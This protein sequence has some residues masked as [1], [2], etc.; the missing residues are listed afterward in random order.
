MLDAEH[1][2]QLFTESP[3]KCL[4][5]TMPETSYDQQLQNYERTW[6]KEMVRVFF[7]D[8]TPQ[9]AE[10]IVQCGLSAERL[11]EIY[12]HAATEDDFDKAIHDKGINSK[13]L[14]ETLWHLLSNPLPECTPSP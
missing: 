1:L 9:Q 11:Q 7:E 4:L 2:K 10:R 13:P 12:H 5:A 6:D 8:I 14:R 3:L